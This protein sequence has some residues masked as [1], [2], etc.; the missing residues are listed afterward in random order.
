MVDAL[1]QNKVR[2]SSHSASFFTL[3]IFYYCCL[4]DLH[5]HTP[6]IPLSLNPMISPFFSGDDLNEDYAENFLEQPRCSSLFSF[7]SI[8]WLCKVYI[9][10]S[11]CSYLGLVLF[12][13]ALSSSPPSSFSKMVIRFFVC[14]V[15]VFL[16]CLEIGHFIKPLSP[17]KCPSSAHDKS[18]NVSTVCVR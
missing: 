2:V 16:I 10:H 9:I 17:D 15:K 6:P 8:L 12:R 11:S 4:C 13:S 7:N 18:R 5:A 1:R 3:M 14:F